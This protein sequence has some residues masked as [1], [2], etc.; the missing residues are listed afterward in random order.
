MLRRLLRWLLY[1]LG[2]LCTLI[3]VAGLLLWWRF[4]AERLQQY[5]VERLQQRLQRPIQVGVVPAVA[6]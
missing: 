3:L 1:S 6:G 5:V 2:V 4:P